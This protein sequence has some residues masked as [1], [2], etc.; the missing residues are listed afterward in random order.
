M[1]TRKLLVLD[2]D[3]TL[4]H[5]SAARL[6]RE[7]E[8]RVFNYFVYE[9]PGVRQF[10]QE[11]FEQFR[12]GIWTASTA[13]YARE[14]LSRVT[15]ISRF[16]FIWSREHCSIAT[17]PVTRRF[18]LLKDIGQLE[19]AGYNPAD[20]IFVDDLPHRLCLSADN[21]IQVRPFTGDRAD[22]ELDELQTYV[23]WLHAVRDVRLVNK[24]AWREE[25]DALRMDPPS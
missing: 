19:L 16:A 5:S 3:E 4:V 20:I 17:H 13:P 22:R 18:D 23:S 21:I 12:V 7:P 25:V 8:H 15:D 6:E 9:R 14:I 11:C 10:L 2:L 24:S 1:T